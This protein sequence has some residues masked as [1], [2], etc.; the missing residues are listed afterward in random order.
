M[1]RERRVAAD[2]FSAEE[3]AGWHPVQRQIVEENI[4][5]HVRRVA[6]RLIV[7]AACGCWYSAACMPVLFG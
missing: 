1:E 5:R 7:A 3:V 6:A 2:T 4:E